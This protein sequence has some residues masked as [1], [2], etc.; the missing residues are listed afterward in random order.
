MR[1][2][3]SSALILG[4]TAN[5]VDEWPSM[6]WTEPR[7]L[8][9]IVLGSL[10]VDARTCQFESVRIEIRFPPDEAARRAAWHRQMGEPDPGADVPSPSPCP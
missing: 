9:A 5:T 3:A 10:D 2:P 8:Q 1:D 4:V 7:N 6:V